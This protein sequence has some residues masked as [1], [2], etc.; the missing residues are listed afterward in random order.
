MIYA[1]S[2]FKVTY[3]VSAAAYPFA[4]NAESDVFP[5]LGKR[6]PLSDTLHCPKKLFVRLQQ[7]IE[8]AA[9]KLNCSLELWILKLAG[10]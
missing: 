9:Y 8:K 3:S 1:C 2:T 10:I 4:R 5:E 7:T 6:Y